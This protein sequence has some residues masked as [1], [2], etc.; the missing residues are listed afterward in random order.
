MTFLA[1][2]GGLALEERLLPAIVADISLSRAVSEPS[3]S[4]R[5]GVDL[6]LS[7]AANPGGL[8]SGTA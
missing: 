6:I 2:T 3:P 5:A 1:T 8:S 7:R 4:G